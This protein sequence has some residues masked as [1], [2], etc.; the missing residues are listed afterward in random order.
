MV[1]VTAIGEHTIAKG[2]ES[3][4]ISL[5]RDKLYPNPDKAA[6][7]ET[8]CNAIDEH[9]KHAVK[10]PVDVVITKTEVVVRDYASG[11]SQD[12]VV[13]VFF[14]FGASTKKDSEDAIGGFGIGAKAPSAYAQSWTVESR[15]KGK[16][17]GYMTQY[18]V[19]HRVIYVEKKVNCWNT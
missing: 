6:L 4:I 10:R 2:S 19:L 17:S 16:H 15:Y 8:I 1:G 5:V 9:R 13:N 7:C 14:A 18:R 11:L 12:D 3:H